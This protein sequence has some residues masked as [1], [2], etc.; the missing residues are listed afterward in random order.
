MA[1]S[2]LQSVSPG[3]RIQ[4]AV[5]DNEFQNILTHPIDLISPSTGA[6]NFALQAHVGLLPSVISA[7]SAS[8]GQVLMSTG[9][10]VAIWATST[11]PPFTPSFT[12][13]ETPFAYSSVVT[14]P[15]GL[16]AYP[17]QVRVV[18]RNVVSTAGFSTGQ[19]IPVQGTVSEQNAAGRGVTYCVSSS[20][21]KISF[22]VSH[23]TLD[24]LTAADVLV[25]SSAWQAVV[26]CWA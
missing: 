10:S 11:A 8:A 4:S 14:V 3:D 1:L 26:R 17:S 15:H 23:R 25:S 16:D 22:G 18:L 5:W 7:T 13:T 9:G 24:I 6:I 21:V 2:Q 12:S 19:E 20:A